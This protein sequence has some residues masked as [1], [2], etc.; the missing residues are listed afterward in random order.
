MKVLLHLFSMGAALAAGL[1]P[2]VDANAYPARGASP[3]MKMGA[4][5]SGRGLTVRGGSWIT[6]EYLAVEIGVFVLPGAVVDLKLSD[7]ALTL[8]GERI[9]RAAQP[10]AM[11]GASV[12]NTGLARQK[13]VEVGGG[14][15]PADVVFG[16]P[17]Q[18]DER[19]P[20]DPG[21]SRRVPPRAPEDPPANSPPLMTADKAI[22]EYA[23]PEGEVRGPVAG[24]LY[25]HYPGKANK[26]RTIDL[27][28]RSEK[29]E[30]RLKLL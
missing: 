24:F 3:R 1:E 20:G 13:G 29:G 12:R 18:T 5:F 2:R 6:G 16:R 9:P 7:F 10:P 8:N 21:V 25:F 15:G 27:L 14:V 22:V 26:I 19:F 28:Y 4:E 23:L 30:V 11:V 17:R